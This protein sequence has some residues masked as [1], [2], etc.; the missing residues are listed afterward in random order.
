MHVGW[1]T[2]TDSHLCP[3]LTEPS[4]GVVFHPEHAYTS[5]HHGFDKRSFGR[6]LTPTSGRPNH[7]ISE[8]STLLVDSTGQGR[9][10]AP[11]RDPGRLQGPG[12]GPCI[13]L[14]GGLPDRQQRSGHA[15]RTEGRAHA[16]PHAHHLRC[17]ANHTT[18][19]SPSRYSLVLPDSCNWYGSDFKRTVI[20]SGGS[21][22]RVRSPSWRCCRQQEQ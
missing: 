9:S 6:G 10:A 4:E 21:S 16:T 18:P 11:A 19:H 20:S 8:S 2:R 12:S 5:S 13:P 15:S 22:S 3:P 1:I 14:G 7:Q 17:P